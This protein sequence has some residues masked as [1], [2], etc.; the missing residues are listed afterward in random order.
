MSEHIV[1]TSMFSMECVLRSSPLECWCA[2]APLAF[3]CL[4]SGLPSVGNLWVF[5]VWS[6]D[7][8]NPQSTYDLKGPQGNDCGFCPPLP[9]PP[10]PGGRGCVA[11]LYAHL[12]TKEPMYPLLPS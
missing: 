9:P 8:L 12:P 1:F 5:I 3:R 2:L 6:W 11:L 7:S 10:V 4:G